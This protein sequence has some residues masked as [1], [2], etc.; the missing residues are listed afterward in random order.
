VIEIEWNEGGCGYLDIRLPRVMV[1]ANTLKNKEM[2][3]EDDPAPA[4]ATFP[5][6]TSHVR[7]ADK[8]SILTTEKNAERL[9]VK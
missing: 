6:Q 4:M 1:V 2:P 5:E 8:V 9:A 7:I 3:C